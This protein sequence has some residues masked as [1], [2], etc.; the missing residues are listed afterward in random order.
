MSW[1]RKAFVNSSIVTFSVAFAISLFILLDFIVYKFSESGVE[2][3]LIP[4]DSGFYQLKPNCDGTERFYDNIYSVATDSNGFRVKD[5]KTGDPKSAEAIFLGDSFTFG[6]NGDWDD[7][8]VGMFANNSNKE[9][10][11]AGVGSYSPTV[12]AFQYE[13]ALSA[14]ILKVPHNVIIA[15]DISDVQDEAGFWEVGTLHPVKMQYSLDLKR[16]Q[17]QGTGKVIA[18]IK[19]SLPYTRKVY[20]F[21]LSFF[22]E[23]DVDA[24]I[25]NLP[26][27][28]FTHTDWTL[29]EK[30]MA[31]PEQN[32]FLPLGVRTG[33]NKIKAQIEHINNIAKDNDG[34]VA[35]LIYPWPGQMVHGQGIFSWNAFARNL[36][37]SIKCVGV[38]DTFD[39]FNHEVNN[40]TSLNKIYQRGDVHFT[41]YGNS[42]V[43][44]ELSSSY[45]EFFE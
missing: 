13:K 39:A 24:S 37:E 10:I 29:L 12:Y 11:N 31:A 35:I 26:R 44:N 9:I 34:R 17:D 1:I 32:G 40:G 25:A 45:S 36:C 33:L 21:I 4:K 27:S 18:E 15:L 28:A 20:K 5:N 38:I 41:K 6:I 7:T 16:S 8:F 3:C 23:Y 43:Y 14:G 42:I 22:S 19:K 2:T 30:T